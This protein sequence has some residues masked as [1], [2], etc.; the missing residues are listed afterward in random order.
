MLLNGGSWPE[1][2]QKAIGTHMWSVGNPKFLLS[3]IVH[4]QLASHNAKAWFMNSAIYKLFD[5][6]F[7]SEKNKLRR[8]ENTGHYFLPLRWL[9]VI[10]AC[11]ALHCALFNLT[12]TGHKWKVPL[13][14]KHN[15]YE[16]MTRSKL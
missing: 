2:L 3:T 11:C 5:D 16:G 4:T 13:P 6:E 10:L 1:T 9:T 8:D 14:F 12:F 15:E 7:F